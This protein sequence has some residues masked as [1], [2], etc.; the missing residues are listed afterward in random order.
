M[1]YELRLNCDLWVNFSLS[2]LQYMVGYL[3]EIC[4]YQN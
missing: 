1:K 2:I 4:M 3:Y